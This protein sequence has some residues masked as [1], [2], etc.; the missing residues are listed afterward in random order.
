[1]RLRGERDARG[2]GEQQRRT[3]TSQHDGTPL[4]TTGLA[5]ESVAPG[6][7]VSGKIT[8]VERSDPA[9]E[10][11]DIVLQRVASGSRPG[12]RHDPHRVALCIEGGAMRGVVSAGMV[13]AIEQLELLNAFDVVYGSSGGALNGA[14]L[15]AGQAALGTTIYY[16][17]IN[18]DKFISFARA[19][20]SRPVVDIDFLVSHVMQH[21][22]PL[23]TTAMLASPIP[24][25]IVSSNVDTGERTV[26]L[27]K[28]RDHLLRL[29]RAGATMPVMSGPPA[30]IDGRRYWDALLT[31][32]VPVPVADEAPVTHLVALL[33]RG[34]GATGPSLSWFDRL[35][36][37]PRIAS[38]SPRLA[39]RY[40]HRSREYVE[41]IRRIDE[42]RTPNGRPVLGIKPR[43]LAIDKLERRRDRL[44]N[45]AAQGFE[46]VCSAF[47][48]ERQ[49]SKSA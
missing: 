21:E 43:G 20:T 12:A 14:Y 1:L 24:L 29:L 40:V 31:E 46:A 33:T 16:E 41:L 22:K 32:P 49:A 23:D 45:G 37:L 26:T 38:Y 48:A 13:V 44:M 18:N 2:G 6:C 4:G 3:D 15:L 28:D 47:A 8:A 7:I 27:A 35:Y 30:Q 11:R 5:V 25:H 36:V 42:G 39:S 19:L 10:V 9:Q 17:N 34:P